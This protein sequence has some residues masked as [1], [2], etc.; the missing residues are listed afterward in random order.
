ML[1]KVIDG[2][3]VVS[4]TNITPVYHPH[5]PHPQNSRNRVFGCTGTGNL[6]CG[7]ALVYIYCSSPY[8]S[9][10]SGKDGRGWGGGGQVRGWE[11]WRGRCVCVCLCLCLCV[12]VSL[13]AIGLSLPCQQFSRYVLGTPQSGGMIEMLIM[14]A[15]RSE[16]LRSPENTHLISFL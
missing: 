4:K 9:R 6:S 13:T 2:Q 11:G 5:P 12:R 16:R 1:K 10:Q 3:P 15:K 14:A 8:C 7:K